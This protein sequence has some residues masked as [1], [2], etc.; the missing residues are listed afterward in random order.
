MVLQLDPGDDEAEQKLRMALERRSARSIA[1]AMRELH[2]TLATG[3]RTTFEDEM[4]QA[5]WIASH[6]HADQKTRDAIARAIMNG[7]DLGVLTAAGQFANVGFSVDWTLVNVAARDWASRHAAEMISQLDDVTRRGVRQAVT[8]WIDNGEPLQ[9]LI[10]DIEPLFGRTRAERIA[11]TE[12][13]NAYASGNR[14]AFQE[15]GVVQAWE[16]RTAMDERVCP[17][18]GPLAGVQRFMGGQ[19]S[20][21]VSQPPAHVG[22][23]CWVVPVLKETVS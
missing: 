5:E 12:I 20:P 18:C 6:V 2:E 10:D 17:V 22:C 11:A 16:W 15:S 14:I 23:R 13:T 9:K 8:R 7:S 21:G 3:A 19:F 1:E 4:M